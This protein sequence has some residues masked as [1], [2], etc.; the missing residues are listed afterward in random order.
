M[1]GA[2]NVSKNVSLPQILIRNGFLVTKNQQKKCG[3]MLPKMYPTE[4]VTVL[5]KNGLNSVH[6]IS[7]N[8]SSSNQEFETEIF[9]IVCWQMMRLR[10][11][12]VFGPFVILSPCG[13]ENHW[14]VHKGRWGWAETLANTPCIVR[15][16]LG[17][18][19]ICTFGVG[20]NWFQAHI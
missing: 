4:N 20:P 16:N 14:G 15:G 13:D 8:A 19:P 6:T 9:I 12:S 2:Q 1:W 17:Q 10:I 18:V 7:P 5:I 11:T 3:N